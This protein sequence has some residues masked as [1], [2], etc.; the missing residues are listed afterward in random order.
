MCG[1]VG[2]VGNAEVAADIYDALTML[3]HRGQD[4]A[5]IMTFKDGKFLQ[6]KGEGLVRDVFRTQHMSQL[7]GNFGI[8]H[9]RYPT[10]G[11]SGTALAQPFYVNSPYGIALAHNGNLTNANKLTADL[12]RSDLRHLNTDSDSEVLLNVFAHELQ[13]LGKLVPEAEDIFSAVEAVHTRCEGGYA[14]VAMIADHGVVAFRDPNG[15]RPLVIGIRQGKHGGDEYMVASESVALDVL[16]FKLLGDVAPGE[17]VYINPNGELIRRQCAKKPRLM[18]CI[19]EHVYFARPDSMMDGISVYKTRMRQGERLARKILRERP[20]HDIDVVIPIPDTSRVAGQSLAHELGVKFREG[21]MK[22]RY[23]GRTFIMPGQNERRKS[24][25]QKLNPVPLEFKDKTVLLV[26]DSIVRGTTCGQIIQ[27]ARDSGARKVYFASAA[28]PVRYP[29]VYGIDMP[30]AS[31]L[32]AHGREVQEICELIGADWM[33]YQD[34]EDLF[35]CSREGNEGIEGFESSVFDG[36]YSAGTIDREYL[37]SVEAARSEGSALR[38]A[39]A[40]DGGVVGLHND[41]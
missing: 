38:L 26:D 17:G 34:L 36:K 37:R 30:A 18:P 6:R 1:L 29:N 31:E 20:D 25:R 11:S 33:V 23:I 9:V 7:L 19:F 28:P 41:N 21:F 27:M 3:Q 32:I 4:A 5:G 16:G 22:N 8:G 40:Q 24:V 14:A 13:R 35:E 12:F 2:I 39:V 15:I 10:Q